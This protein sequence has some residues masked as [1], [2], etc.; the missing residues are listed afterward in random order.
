MR[1]RLIAA[2]LSGLL[3]VSALPSAPVRAAE[4]QVRKI[5][6]AQ[7]V[8]ANTALAGAVSARAFAFWLE[9]YWQPDEVRIQLDYQATPLAVR[10]HSSVTLAVNGTKFHSFRPVIQANGTTRLEIT[11]PLRLLTPGSNTVTVTGYLQ[12]A[13]DDKFCQTLERSNN[14]LQLYDT[15][16]VAVRYT[17]EPFEGSIRDFS[18]RFGGLD[19]PQGGGCAVEVPQASGTDELTAAAYALTGFSRSS[20]L[21]NAPVPLTY[22]GAPRKSGDAPVALIG[23]YDKLPDAVKPVIADKGLDQ[24]AVLQVT[25]S[26]GRPLLVVT[27]RNPALLIKAGKLAANPELMQ[28]IDSPSSRVDE[29]T[30]VE[31]PTAGLPEGVRL[32]DTGDK[33]TGMQH[34]EKAYFVSLP[35]NRA[36]AGSSVVHLDFRYARN[37]DF[38]RSLVTILVNDK[39]I[40]SKKLTRE[41]AD[42]DT[43]ALPIP[44][45]V[46]VS[47]SFSVTV[48]FDLE[49]THGSCMEPDQL[50][51][52]A[53]V[54]PDSF[55][56][57]QTKDRTALTLSNFPY[58]FL[59]DGSFDQ[60]AVV[61]PRARDERS[62]LTVSNLFHLMGRYA[63]GNRGDLQ[64]YEDDAEAGA[65]DEL[66]RRN[67]IAIGGYADNAVLREANPQL[68]F[69]YREDG[70][71]F[72][73]NEKITLNPEY[74]KRI[75]TLQLLHSPFEAGR[76]LL[77][78]TGPGSEYGFLASKLIATEEAKW[79]IYGDGVITDKDGEIRPYRF[80]AEAAPAD[81]PA[82]RL[83]GRSDLIGFLTA[84]VSCAALVLV[85]LLLLVRKYRRKR[86]SEA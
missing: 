2:M 60:V 21:A 76:T 74:A 12:T 59:S 25:E 22:A 56:R 57:L 68:Y 29:T 63:E 41:L 32:T 9:S 19:T 14:W 23:L 45:N 82:D 84:A 6:T 75:G 66:K 28:Q 58:P 72:L 43:L 62:L 1:I 51:P 69:R 38:E 27:S 86:R 8:S 37:L 77:A 64:F 40:G 33:L 46:Q 4:P 47:G 24:A 83:F 30:E 10:E 34:Q 16:E 26:G 15:S 78:V 7:L 61:V 55:L 71:G 36:V 3:L 48:A 73:S 50:T 52:W 49:L 35:V 20:R 31:T 17:A 85:S 44:A 65:R 80:Q 79:R 54:T 11:V 5:H 13:V 42:G 53:F 18:R 39:P 81:N 70:A 67:I